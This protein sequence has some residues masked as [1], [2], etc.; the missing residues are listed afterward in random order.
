MINFNFVR[1]LIVCF[2]AFLDAC[3]KL[4]AALPPLSW[5]ALGFTA[6]LPT[7]NRLYLQLYY[8]NDT[9]LLSF[10]YSIQHMKDNWIL[11]MIL[12]YLSIFYGISPISFQHHLLGY[13]AKRC[14]MFTPPYPLWSRIEIYQIA[15]T[16]IDDL[17]RDL[18]SSFCSCL[19]GLDRV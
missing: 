19:R 4:Q 18:C 11:F 13:A 3:Q 1:Y 5:T 14:N 9:S 16:F 10:L 12:T 2:T 7:T 17:I 8:L 6:I 15:L